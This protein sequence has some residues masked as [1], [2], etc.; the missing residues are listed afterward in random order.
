MEPPAPADRV[1]DI[2]LHLELR[3]EELEGTVTASGRPS[4]AFLGWVGLIGALDA[5]TGPVLPPAP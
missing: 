3:G 1:L 5:L 4:Q 2:A